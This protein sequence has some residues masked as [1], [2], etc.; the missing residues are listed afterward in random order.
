M[1]KMIYLFLGIF[2]LLQI[3][4]TLGCSGSKAQMKNNPSGNIQKQ[5]ANP[6]KKETPAAP[7]QKEVRSPQGVGEV[8]PPQSLAQVTPPPV[9]AKPEPST[10][11][12][13]PPTS[14]PPAPPRTTAPPTPPSP[15]PTPPPTAPS[16]PP[17]PASPARPAEPRAGQGVVFNFDNADLYEVIRIMAEIMKMNYIIDPK[18]RGVVNIHTSGQIA[19]EDVFSIFQTILKLNGATAVKKENIYEIVPFGDAKKLVPPISAKELGKAPLEM[20]YVIQII[21][22][23]YIP[24]AEASKL[25]K[26]FLSDGA[27][28]VEHPPHNVLILG[29]VAPNIKKC[30]DIIGLFDIDIFTDM[31][32][33]IYPVL[34]A[35]VTEVAKEMERI[36]SSFEVSTKS[37]R[38]VGITFTPITRINSLL[39]V[40]SIPNIFEKVEGWLKELDKVPAEGTK[41]GVF[42]YYCQNSKAKDLADVLKQIFV[43]AKDKKVEFKEKVVTPE[44]APRGVRPSTTPA[45]TTAPREEAAG[46]PEGE[47]NI[48]VDES[49][50]ALVIRAFARDYRSILETVKK[51][52]IYPKQVLIEV[53]LAEITLGDSYRFGVEWSRFL[54]SNPPNAQEIIM[55]S[56]PPTDP[57]NQPLGL[58]AIRYSIVELGGRVSAALSAAA[59][60][61]RL[62]VISSPHI[63]ASNNKEAKIQVGSSQPILT[64]T[65]TTTATAGTNVV[66]GSIEYK[67]IGIILTVT[68]RVSD[69]GLVTLEISV[70]DSTVSD[71]A[72]GSLENVPVFGKRTA[73][74]I[75]SILEGQ[76]IVIGGLIQ[77]TKNTVKSGVPF[78]SKIPVIGAL[79]GTQSYIKNKTELL[80]LL[81]PHV[82]A[83]IYQSNAVTQ[84]FKEKVEGLRK[85]LE[86]K[87]DKK[88]TK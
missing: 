14:V 19:T 58:A 86:K 25:V 49:N 34:N 84:E 7:E 51:L 28:I 24:V 69:G 66:E 4:G 36:F 72:L 3:F 2:I 88:K 56:T 43:A 10:T 12:T 15:G 85:D 48:V 27:D 29:D 70:E 67:D 80:I 79:F 21:P 77:D 65:Y 46:V 54:S 22:L 1:R 32:V 20:R 16:P 50:N 61:N 41:L 42:V 26:P 64:N 83:D 8:T 23:K 38:G 75:L 59:I 37:G 45:P 33:R 73:K 39:V 62:N 71:T 11:P 17:F 47:I 74:T 68:P 63:L 82:I 52:D 9:P 18:V 30:L 81:T 87:I 60:D 35:D 57:F 13:P 6:P 5:Q 31:R 78:L 44:P 53:L 55:G 40:S 76:T